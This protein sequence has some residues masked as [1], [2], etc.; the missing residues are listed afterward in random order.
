[1]SH[2]CSACE[3][4]QLCT[5]IC[6]LGNGSDQVGNTHCVDPDVCNEHG[7]DSPPCLEVACG[8][9][10]S[11]PTVCGVAGESYDIVCWDHVYTSC[12]A[13]GTSDCPEEEKCFAQV[14][15]MWGP[16]PGTCVWGMGADVAGD[17]CTSEGFG[18]QTTTGNDSCDQ[19]SM[20]W[21]GTLMTGPFDGICQPY[22]QGMDLQCPEQMSCQ[23]VYTDFYLCLPI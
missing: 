12:L 1:M 15:E 13:E 22:C 18:I 4:G 2:P 16:W 20:C 23:E 9:Y 11:I 10:Y 14:S 8:S 17:P 6:F 3:E 5:G 7:F 21:N 19:D